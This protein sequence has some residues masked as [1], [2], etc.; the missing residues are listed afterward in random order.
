MVELRTHLLAASLTPVLGALACHGGGAAHADGTDDGGSST[1]QP[2][3]SDTGVAT[4]SG[5]TG[6]ADDTGTTGESP[7]AIDPAP[8]GLRRLVAHQYVDSIELLLGPEAAAAAA[9]P[10]DP[11]LGGFDAIAA[12]EAT[13]APAD[14]EQYERSAN[15]IALAAIQ[16]PD[17]L[18][19]QVPCLVSVVPEDACYRSLARDF[20]RLAWRRPLADEEIDIF[21][22]LGTEARAWDDGEFWTGVQ[23]VL[24]ALLQSPRF[25]YIVELGHDADD[26]GA[27]QLDGFEMATRLSF[28]L[29]D[30]TPD[31]LLLDRAAAGELDDADGVRAVATELLASERARPTVRRFWGELLM[32][33]GLPSKGK[34]PALFPQFDAELAASMQEETFRLVDDLVFE[35]EGDVL[36]LFDADYTWVDAR[37]ADLYGVAAPPPGQW[38]E[39]ELPAS[40]GRA[41]LMTHAGVMAMLSHGTLNSP[42]RRGLFVQE[43]L[44]C[45]DI[46]PVPPTVNPVLPDVTDPMSLRDR[47]E[48]LHT[49]QNGCGD[50][51]KQMD[52]LGFAFEHFDPI[53]AWRAQDNGFPIDASGTVDGVGS[54]SDARELMALVRDDPRLPRCL[55]DQ[56]YTEA[57][58]FPP[59]D[60]QIEALDAVDLSF[61]Q[62]DHRL[63]RLM[64]ELAAS[65][66]FR[67]VGEPK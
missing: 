27:R 37:L 28:F 32:T 35:Q 10:S 47:L 62:D 4:S 15:Q 29:H 53:G 21:A 22:N 66:V 33:R 20:G 34:D 3:V 58:G 63:Q 41:G 19:A 23:Y 11:S 60:A 64:V 9:A 16:H 7:P 56:V 1:G 39:A 14:V 6:M 49:S 48:Q 13:P 52:P 12:A 59:T 51:H 55:V 46:P 43:Q 65:D 50:C 30:R 8:A 45:N 31:A 38:L 17:T 2:A 54:F 57:L 26:G 67:R 24:V 25:L 36:D 40:Q 61:E 18:T 5:S 42:T 44:L